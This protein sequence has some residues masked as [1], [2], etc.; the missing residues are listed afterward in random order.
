MNGKER[1]RLVRRFAGTNDW[2]LEL[3]QIAEEARV[4]A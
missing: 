1:R 3:I 4:T 2:R